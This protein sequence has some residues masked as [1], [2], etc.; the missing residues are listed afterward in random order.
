VSTD[1]KINTHILC[2]SCDGE[3]F[4]LGDAHVPLDT[5]VTHVKC[6]LRELAKIRSDSWREAI[7]AL[8]NEDRWE[9][10]AERV[11]SDDAE[12]F[13]GAEYISRGAILAYLESLAPKETP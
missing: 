11:S 13:E 10:W 6:Q 5:V 2:D 3:V 7:E 8:R 4:E 12:R 1:E 9:F